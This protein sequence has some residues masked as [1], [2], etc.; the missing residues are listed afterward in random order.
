MS[1]ESFGNRHVE[2]FLN[3]SPYL[4]AFQEMAKMDKDL[5]IPSS[6]V[7]KR[8]QGKTII[9][10]NKVLRTPKRNELCLCGSGKKFKKYCGK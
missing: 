4:H 8:V 1:I 2:A 3:Y 6:K 9:P 10:M 5:F 7:D